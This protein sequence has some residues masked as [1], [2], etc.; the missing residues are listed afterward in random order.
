MKLTPYIHFQRSHER[1]M[2]FTPRL[3]TEVLILKGM[4]TVQCQ[5]L[6]ITYKRFYMHDWFLEKTGF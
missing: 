6:K 1:A 2:N 4:V 3:S 5:P